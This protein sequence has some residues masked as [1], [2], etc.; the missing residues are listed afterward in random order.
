MTAGVSFPRSARGLILSV[1]IVIGL[2]PPISSPVMAQERA[3]LGATYTSILVWIADE[4]GYFD[5]LP[6]DIELY[7]SG[8]TTSNDLA[9]GKLQL[10]TSSHLAFVSNA[11]G[12]PNLRLLG[13]VSS[14]RTVKLLARNDRVGAFVEDLKGKK[15]GV[16]RKSAAEYFL[17]EVLFLSGLNMDDANIID[18]SPAENLEAFVNG[19]IDASISWEP[20]VYEALQ[21]LGGDVHGFP[22]QDGQYYYFV[23][24]GQGPWVAKNHDLVAGVFE[25]LKKAERYA[26]DHPDAAKQLLVQRHGWD[27]AFVDYLWPQHSLNVSLSQDLVEL[28]ER[29]ARWRQQEGLTDIETLPNMLEFIESGPLRSAAPESVRIIE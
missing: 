17:W 2:V 25:A 6:L 1:L 26:A 28:L 22:E 13:A 10:A 21:R 27:S 23:L 19:G 7:L 18:L 11:L 8:V 14:S 15:I 20:H 29:A 24:V 3:K 12:Q 16:M 9:S 4:L 5:H